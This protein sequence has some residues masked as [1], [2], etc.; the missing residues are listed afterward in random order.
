MVS[1][2]SSALDFIVK[3]KVRTAGELRLIIAVRQSLES[4][5]F[6]LS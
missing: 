5:Q 6:S 2:P 4:A 1:N 3:V